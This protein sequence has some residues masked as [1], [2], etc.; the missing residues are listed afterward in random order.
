MPRVSGKE[1]LGRL[2]SSKRF[3]RLPIVIYST[4]GSE[5]DIELTLSMGANIYIVKPADFSKLKRAIENVLKIQWRYE[6]SSLDLANYL[7]VID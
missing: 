3:A 5:R 4:S 7:M 2:R 6:T 1:V